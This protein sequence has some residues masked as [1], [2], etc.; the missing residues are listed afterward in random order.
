VVAAA[1]Y[2]ASRGETPMVWGGNGRG[3]LG[4]DGEVDLSDYRAVFSTGGAYDPRSGYR[5]VG[6]RRPGLKLV[7]SP[8]KSVAELGV[9][10][11]AEDM[12]ATVDAERDATVDHL[13]RLVAERGGRRGR[14]QTRVATGRPDLGDFEACNNESGQRWP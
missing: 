11:R 5:L 8:S 3:L 14:G 9:I 10:G 7:V 6:C 2:Y 1:A 12:H 13:D 4:L